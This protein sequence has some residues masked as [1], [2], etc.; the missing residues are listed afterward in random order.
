MKVPQFFKK[1]YLF[2]ITL[3]YWVL[4]LYIMAAFV[5]WFITLETQNRQMYVF[6]V[7]ELKRDDPGYYD[8]VVEI[9][10][11][12][13]MKSIQYIGEGSTL[14]LLMLLGAVFVYRAVRRQIITSHQQQNFMMAV[15][16]EL[17]TP[18]AVARLNLETML[19]RKLDESQQQRLLQNTLQEAVRLNELCN[20]I[21]VTAQLETGAYSISRQELD[22][23]S[24]VQHSADEFSV[25]YSQRR[26]NT[27]IQPELFVEGESLLLQLL[28]SNLIENALKYSAKD[29]PVSVF[30][31][32][33]HK[34]VKI[35]IADGGAGIPDE[36]KK[37]VFEKF[38]RIGSESTRT[39]KGTGLGLYLCKKI[40]ADHKGT[41]TIKDNKPH[42]SIFTVILQ[43]V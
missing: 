30:V 10:K 42:G 29:E 24:L 31:S 18:I 35:E 26:I 32:A 4:L 6:R 17:K 36:E 16:H 9:D 37:L 39:T 25:R 21:L 34:H 13:R 5:F 2:F 41:I 27:S 11:A 22:I 19:K 8:K 15:T 33:Q 23:S 14:L 20:N 28:I 1:R 40:T 7:G 38:Y 3:S 12:H 43:S